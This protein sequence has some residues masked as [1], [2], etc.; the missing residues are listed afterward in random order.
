MGT[1]LRLEKKVDQAMEWTKGTKL[2]VSWG[3]TSNSNMQLM[4]KILKKSWSLKVN[5]FVVLQ[6]ISVSRLFR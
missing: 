6:V 5:E 3:L 2:E 4:S 1:L